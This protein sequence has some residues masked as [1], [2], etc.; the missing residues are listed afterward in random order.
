MGHRGDGFGIINDGGT[1]VE[2]DDGREGRPDARN[3]AF[4]F[5][6][7]HQGRFFAHFVS[8]GAGLGDDLEFCVGAKDVLAEKAAIVGVGDCLFHDFEEIAVL[9]AQVDEAHFGANGQAGNDGS[10]N[11][12]MGVVQKDEV[13]FAGAGLALVAIDE[14]V[15]RLGG[16]FGD[17]GPLHARREPRAAAAAK[18]GGLQLVDDPVGA[19]G[20]RFPGRFIAPER[21][22]AVNVCRP[23]AKALGDDLDLIGMGDQFRHV[24]PGFGLASGT[25]RARRGRFP[26]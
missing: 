13:V 21:E 9:A 11:H 15:L 2:A 24:F 4:A 1:A 14:D 7:L 3:A 19:L 16:L 18:I 17:E 20:E 23:L 6:R 12:G 5:E 8:A 26:A 25:G 22:I 10:L